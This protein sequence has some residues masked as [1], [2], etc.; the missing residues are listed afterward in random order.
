MYPEPIQAYAFYAEDARR[1]LLLHAGK[2][3]PPVESKTRTSFKVSLS[4]VPTVKQS[5]S[6]L[7]LSE[8]KTE[9]AVCQKSEI[10]PSI[11]EMFYQLLYSTVS[12]DPHNRVRQLHLRGRVVHPVIIVPRRVRANQGKADTTSKRVGEKE[13][14]AG[15]WR[16]RP[17]SG[18]SSTI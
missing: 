9:S 11:V 12:E 7:A 14:C 6:S 10:R 3:D 8:L 17:S 2:G 13:G 5:W 16:F 1:V 4:F 18:R 15:R